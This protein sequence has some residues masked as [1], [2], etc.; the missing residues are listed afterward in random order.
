MLRHKIN[1][2]LN[3][4]CHLVGVT[5][6][7]RAYTTSNRRCLQ[8]YEKVTR[9]CKSLHPLESGGTTGELEESWPLAVVREHALVAVNQIPSYG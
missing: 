6:L 5:R 7:A 1:R 4:V 8:I 3:L 2:S 9:V